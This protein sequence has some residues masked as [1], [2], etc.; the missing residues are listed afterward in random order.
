MDPDELDR[1]LDELR[2]LAVDELRV[3]LNDP[4]A[5]VRREARRVA[6][7]VVVRAALREGSGEH[8]RFGAE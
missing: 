4:D 3:L 8:G 1:R 2:A 6:Y 5:D 7:R